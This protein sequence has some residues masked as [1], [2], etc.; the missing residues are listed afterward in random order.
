MTEYN[1]IISVGHDNLFICRTLESVFKALTDIAI[2]ENDTDLM[3]DIK[4]RVN[5]IDNLFY[6]SKFFCVGADY[7]V[8]KI[9]VKAKE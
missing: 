7:W 4:G 9:K 1:Y 3:D 8:E 2:E 6:G 5:N